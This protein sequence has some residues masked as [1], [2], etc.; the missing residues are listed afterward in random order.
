MAD[1]SQSLINLTSEYNHLLMMI[2]E[3]GGEM[4]P[5]IEERLAVNAATMAAKADVYD[6]VISKLETEETHWKAEADRFASVARACANARERLRGAI[7]ATMIETKR[8]D[9]MGDRATF[10]LTNA[11]P[12]LVIDEPSAIPNEYMTETVVRDV[13]KDKVKSALK[14][15]FEVPGCKLEPVYVLRSGVARK[16]K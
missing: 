16:T 10:K 5:D 1:S 6:F 9:I 3:A 7:K 2:M 11:A 8:V 4:T 13:N 15:G 14:D 12:K